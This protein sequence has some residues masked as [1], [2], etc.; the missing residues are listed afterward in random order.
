MNSCTNTPFT[1]FAKVI[2]LITMNMRYEKVAFNKKLEQHPYLLTRDIIAGAAA[3]F[4]AL[5]DISFIESDDKA[6]EKFKSTLLVEKHEQLWQEIWSRHNEEEFEEF[7]ELK[8]YRLDINNLHQYVKDKDCVEFGCGNAAFAFALLKRGARRVTGVDFGEKQITFANDYVKRKG[9]ENKA[10]FMV[11]SVINTEL[12]DSTYDFAVSNGVFHHLPQGDIEKAL[13]EVKRVMKKGGAFWYYVDGKGAI[14][15]DLWD[16]S[17]EILKTT[18]I[19]MIENIFKVMNIKRN[20]AVH[21]MDGLNATYIHST[22]DEVTA[23]LSAHGF[24]NFKRL[25]GGTGTDFDMDTVE[26]DPYGKEKFGEGDIR[27]ICTLFEK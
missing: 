12:P 18:D 19:I 21:I 26:A 17:V 24:G 13:S 9:L 3:Q 27:I 1:V 14:S 20:K 11:K 22:Y 2:T 23:Q 4:S 10:N 6:I 15:M 25:T 5:M 16:T 7:I 8:A